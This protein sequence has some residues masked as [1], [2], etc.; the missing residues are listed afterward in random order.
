MFSEPFPRKG[1]PWVPISAVCRSDTVSLFF[2]QGDLAKKGKP[3]SKNK[4]GGVTI[5][6]TVEVPGTHRIPS[7]F[8]IWIIERTG[9]FS[10]ALC[11]RM[12]RA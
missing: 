3:L 12:G 8:R 7:F 10:F 9:V 11:H 5:L 6:N 1:T 2:E 4:V